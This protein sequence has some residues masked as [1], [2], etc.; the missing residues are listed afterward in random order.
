[1]SSFDKPHCD[2][3]DDDGDHTDPCLGGGYA[4]SELIDTNTNANTNENRSLGDGYKLKMKLWG[5]LKRLNV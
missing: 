5:W 1:M 2:D 3:D 4:A